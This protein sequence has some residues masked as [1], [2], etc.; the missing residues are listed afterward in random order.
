MISPGFSG[1]VL[2]S[3]FASLSFR[4]LD[5]DVITAIMICITTAVA[6]ILVIPTITITNSQ[7]LQSWFNNNSPTQR[8]SSNQSIN[9]NMLANLNQVINR[10][11]KATSL[12]IQTHMLHSSSLTCNPNSSLTCSHSPKCSNIN[13][14]AKILKSKI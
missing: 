3:S 14:L 13:S 9:S 7:V 6:T 2:C 11:L 4:L 10:L 12:K 8:L 1:C 5:V